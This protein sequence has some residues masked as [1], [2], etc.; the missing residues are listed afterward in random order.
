M[1]AL[2]ILRTGLSIGADLGMLVLALIGA[3]VIIFG[4]GGK[5]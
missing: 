5:R 3:H 2:E 4:R 1:S